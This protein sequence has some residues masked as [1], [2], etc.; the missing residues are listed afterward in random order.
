MGWHLLSSF[1]VPG[2]ISTV[3]RHHEMRA[4][5]ETG[6]RTEAGSLLLKTSGTV[7]PDG[8]SQDHGILDELSHPS[9]PQP[10]LSFTSAPPPCLAQHRDP[11]SHPDNTNGFCLRAPPIG[12]EHYMDD[13]IS[14]CQQNIVC[15]YL[16]VT[17]EEAKAQRN[18]SHLLRVTQLGRSSVENQIQAIKLQNQ[19]INR[20]TGM[21]RALP[22]MSDRLCSV[23]CI[24]ILL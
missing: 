7:T 8:R 12:Q 20:N 14:S 6:Q 9:E 18:I 2:P 22:S 21:S 10:L 13:H 4:W 17:G 24:C 1:W 3:A 23:L 15:S 19:A 5:M 16:Y 11:G